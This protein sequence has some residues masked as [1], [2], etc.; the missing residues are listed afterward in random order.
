MRGV[1]DREL[2]PREGSKDDRSQCDPMCYIT[3]FNVTSAALGVGAGSTIHL[4][5]ADFGK[6][7]ALSRFRMSMNRGFPF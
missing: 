1:R 3:L 2:Q 6:I 5:F 4:A 7:L